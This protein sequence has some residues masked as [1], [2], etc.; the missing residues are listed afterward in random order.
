[1]TTPTVPIEN[2]L[3]SQAE[4]STHMAVHLESLAS[5]YGQMAAL[6]DS[7]AGELFSEEDLQGRSQVYSDMDLITNLLVKDMNRD[8]NELPSIMGE[9]EESIFS[10]ESS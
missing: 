1:M 3:E 8:T 10:I 9:L 2:I 5:H 7:E 4:V 6:R